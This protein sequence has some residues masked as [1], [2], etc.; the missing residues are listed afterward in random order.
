MFPWLWFYAP[1]FHFPWSGAVA[2]RIAP[3]THWFFSGIRPGAG[4]AHIEEQAF[5]VATTA[6]R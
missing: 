3:D 6:A 5:G 1:Q 2:Q 4:D